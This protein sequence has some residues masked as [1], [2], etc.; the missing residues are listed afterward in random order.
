MLVDI[1]FGVC[2]S[3]NFAAGK[4]H[5]KH[6][7]LSY[8]DRAKNLCLRQHDGLQA[9]E[10]QHGQERAN[11]GSV[12][13]IEL[14]DNFCC[15]IA[16]F[17]AQIDG[18]MSAIG[19]RHVIWLTTSLFEPR[20]QQINQLV[21]GYPGLGYGQSYSQAT[22]A[23]K[24][25]PTTIFLWAGNNDALVAD[26]TGMPSSMTPLATFTTQYQALITELTTMTSAHLVIAKAV[27]GLL[28]AGVEPAALV[29]TGLDFG[30]RNRSTGLV[31]HR[32]FN[33]LRVLKR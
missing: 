19:P 11:L 14:G 21:L 31:G 23:L 17:G 30:A 9:H 33:P 12:V 22:F 2:W 6:L 15:D 28:D 32:A 1:A 13:V 10:F 7:M 26:I 4:H 20:Q 25:N 24:A 18:A 16:Q 27:L 8:E 29:Q 5:I 3:R